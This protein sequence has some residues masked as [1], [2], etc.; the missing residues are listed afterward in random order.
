MSAG[1]LTE[2]Q[3]EI[4]KSLRDR[5]NQETGLLL[6]RAINGTLPINDIESICRVINDEYLM[7]GIK[8]GYSP[9]EYGH[10]LESLLDLINRP[11]IA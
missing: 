5:S 6:D 9:N 11:R 1:Y 7:K 2:R 3:I 4:L 8:E 10:E